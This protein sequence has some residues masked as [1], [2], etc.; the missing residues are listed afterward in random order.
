[1]KETKKIIQAKE[2]LKR[3]IEKGV[4]HKNYNAASKVRK[5]AKMILTGE[6]QSEEIIKR[7]IRLTQEQ[8]DQKERIVIPITPQVALPIFAYWYRLKLIDDYKLS[9]KTGNEKQ[10]E[11]V[12]QKLKKYF[13]GWSIK[14]YVLNEMLKAQEIDPNSWIVFEQ[15]TEITGSKAEVKDMYAVIIPCDSVI[16]FH[17]KNGN[18]TGLIAK[19]SHI[20]YDSHFNEIELNDYH[21]Y[22]IG[23]TIHCTE[24]DSRVKEDSR[25]LEGY[26]DLK[27][28]GGESKG[29]LYKVKVFENMTTELPAAPLGVYQ[30]LKR[31]GL[32][33]TPLEPAKFT[34]ERLIKDSSDLDLIKTLHAYPEKSEYVKRCNHT[35]NEHG[36]CENG[37][38]GG[39]MESE[40]YRCRA[41]KG[42]G[43]I[44]VTNSQEVRRL[45]LPDD[46]KDT[47]ELSKLVH[48]HEKPIEILQ[49][50]R[51]EVDK[52]I[53]EAARA[54]FHVET[55]EKAQFQINETATKTRQE[56]EKINNRIAPFAQMWARL[57]EL[58]YRVNYQY[59]G[60]NTD[61]AQIAMNIESLDIRT[62]DEL[63]E[64]LKHARESGAPMEVIEA[65]ENK[66]LQKQFRNEP[67]KVNSIIKCN[68][69][70]PWR[71]KTPEQV[72]MIMEDLDQFDNDVI[73][74][75]YFTWICDYLMKNSDDT[76]FYLLND[77]ELQKK[78][79]EAIEAK[80]STIKKRE[81]QEINIP[82]D[83]GA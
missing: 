46:P 75:N 78:W 5:R 49:E 39:N 37:W 55:I 19:F 56:W 71:D 24:Y 79:N 43:K 10:Q 42:Y 73:A 50:F 35:H 53:I 70:K 25:K 15:Q 31:N 61:G 40:E 59:N 6:G 68:E 4:T 22:G 21:V 7:Q 34:F 63:I 3:A 45:I 82:V 36:E 62:L 60:I 29:K 13:G 2:W 11:R 32:F 69:M 58:G 83:F 38:Y 8:K 47:H 28:E 52:G 74:Y 12:D 26:Q 16:D 23:F 66:I 17:Q 64:N 72:A 9:L 81:S 80:K 33:A 48:Y 77:T 27:I 54:V 76:P 41:C 51:K 20:E 65:L 18:N 57:V 1:M 14:E 67:G 30:S 44:S